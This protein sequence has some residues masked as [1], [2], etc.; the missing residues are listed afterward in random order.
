MSCFIYRIRNVLNNTFYIGQTTATLQKRF[1]SHCYGAAKGCNYLLSKAIR[2][3]GRENFVIEELCECDDYELDTLEIFFIRVYNTN[4]LCGGHG[5]NMTDGGN[6]FIT[7]KPTLETKRLRAV[8]I[9]TRNYS[10]SG[11]VMRKLW[12]TDE[13]RKKLQINPDVS[14]EQLEDENISCTWDDLAL[15]HSVTQNTVKKW[16]KMYKIVKLDNDKEHQR[17]KSWTSEEDDMLCN[18]RRKNLLVSDIAKQMNRTATSVRKRLE[19]L[20]LLGIFDDKIM[21]NKKNCN[22][23]HKPWTLEEETLVLELYDKDR[24]L[25][26]IAYALTRSTSSVGNKIKRLRKECNK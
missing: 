13:F 2:K 22:P 11:E 23:L 9:R 18:F 19:R 26:E 16:F 20:R 5:Y 1:Q 12:E 6:G 21:Y 14:K 10:H 24:L 15:K 25:D 4:V 17:R 8:R 7:R 3:Y